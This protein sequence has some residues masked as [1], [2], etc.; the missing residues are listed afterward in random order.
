MAISPLPTYALL[1]PP[2]H[3]IEDP[4]HLCDSPPTL[5]GNLQDNLLPVTTTVC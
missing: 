1:A 2:P 4:Y 5:A 3:T